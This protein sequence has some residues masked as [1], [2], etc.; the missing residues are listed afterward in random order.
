MKFTFRR[1]RGIWFLI[2][3]LIVGIS[4]CT[5]LDKKTALRGLYDTKHLRP[6][7]QLAY[8]EK[9]GY[10]SECLVLMEGPVPSRMEP[11][12]IG[13]RRSVRDMYQETEVEVAGEFFPEEWPVT[14]YI[15]GLHV[16]YGYYQEVVLFNTSFQKWDYPR[17][18]RLYTYRNMFSR[19][20][21]RNN[22]Y[23]SSNAMGRPDSTYMRGFYRGGR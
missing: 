19:E 10:N 3:I 15:Y 16:N 6:H 21:M 1:T 4:E 7:Q 17:Y 11:C 8:A 22:I 14:G 12:S 18:H 20:V 23:G 2:S 5:T 13:D 9:Y